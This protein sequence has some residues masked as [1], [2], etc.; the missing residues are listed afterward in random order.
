MAKVSPSRLVSAKLGKMEELEQYPAW[1]E[2]GQD[3]NFRRTEVLK[4]NLS[5]QMYLEE[6]LRPWRILVNSA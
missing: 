3:S 1:D 5:A 2:R 4:S 6:M